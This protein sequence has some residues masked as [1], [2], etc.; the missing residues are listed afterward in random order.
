LLR[1][2]GQSSR[3]GPHT[4][5]E[6]LFAVDAEVE[7]DDRTAVLISRLAFDDGGGASAT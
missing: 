7:R 5:M 3:R 4:V 2:L 6:T 1:R